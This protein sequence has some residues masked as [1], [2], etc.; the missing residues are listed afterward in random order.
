MLP[1]CQL[2]W[3]MRHALPWGLCKERMMPLGVLPWIP[4]HAASHSA[5]DCQLLGGPNIGA[6]YLVTSVA[7]PLSDPPVTVNRKAASLRTLGVAS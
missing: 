4:C 5:E 2:L 6:T 3:S 1:A 7:K